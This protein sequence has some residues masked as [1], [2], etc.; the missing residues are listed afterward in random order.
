MTILQDISAAANWN[1][2]VTENFRSVS[3]AGLYGINPA[4]TTGLTLGYLG[5]EFNGVTVANGTVSL[6][7]SATNYVVAHRTTGAVTAATTTTNWLNTGTYMQLYQ[8]VAGTSTFTIATT[9]DKRQAFGGSGSGGSVAG[10]DKQIQYNATGAFGAEAGFEYDY[11]TNTLTVAN[12]TFTGLALTAA[13]TTSTAGLRVPH[14]AAPTSPTN[15]DVWT[16]TAGMYARI[17]GATVGP[18]S[19]GGSFTG[20]TLTTALNEAPLVTIASSSTVAIGAAAA[21][22]ISVTGTTTI[23]AFDTIA[24]GARRVVVF[25]GILTLTHNAT[26]L[27]L[28]TAANITTAAGDVA[29]F[30]SLGAGNWRCVSYM[31]ASGSAVAGGGAGLTNFTEAVNT[32]AP[33]A[34]VPVVSLT[35]T[36]A[37]ASVDVALV[38]KGTGAL[39]AQ[40]ADNT[41]TGGNKRGLGA[42]DWQGTRSAATQ[43][44]SGIYSVISGGRQNTASGQYSTVGGGIN[45]AASGTHCF[46]A[47][48][49]T[50]TLT[51]NHSVLLGGFSQSCA[52]TQ[53]V[54]VGGGTNT[55]SSGASSS[56]I[57][58]GDN[59]II[60][61]I[62]T[63]VGGGTRATDRGLTAVQVQSSGRFTNVGDAQSMR[64]VLRRQTTDATPS[65]L[66]TS[67]SA[68]AAA[69]GLTMSDSSCYAFKALVVAMSTGPVYASFEVKGC[70]KR[71]NAAGTAIVGTV[72]STSLG[73]DAGAASWA[74]TAVANTTLGALEIQ[75]TGAAATSIKWVASVVTTEVTI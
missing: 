64:V 32:S 51:G 42:I 73:A 41:A 70:I 30:V 39:T 74:C 67:G 48:G 14:G 12:A 28:P 50:N 24:S 59:N 7:A 21:N 33:N 2:R 31:R 27:I 75:V 47:G 43:V 4:T 52:G 6:T 10:S 45:I 9:S 57:V 19:A 22:S 60:S 62:N 58:A 40:V 3:P 55:V 23:T 8:F 17:N 54:I 36:N 71:T 72:T 29:E 69:T 61:G 15:G 35:A 1:L 37:A 25:A 63:F 65:S 26:T 16:T 18:L 68:P 53:N 49:D 44:G 20:G 5:G 34:T 13:S 56:A 46:A 38:S 11:T 66:S